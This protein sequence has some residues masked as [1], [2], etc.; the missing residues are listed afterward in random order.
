MDQ[1]QQQQQQQVNSMM[2][3][4][5]NKVGK[6][7]QK[8]SPFIIW[9]LVKYGTLTCAGGFISLDIFQKDIMLVVSVGII[10]LQGNIKICELSL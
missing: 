5:M 7:S 9:I 8:W 1:Q 3:T 2:V 4:M 10:V 6:V